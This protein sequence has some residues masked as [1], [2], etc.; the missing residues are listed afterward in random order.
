MLQA[1]A[2]A[3]PVASIRIEKSFTGAG[4]SAVDVQHLLPGDVPSYTITV[5]NTGST[6]VTNLQVA[7]Q[8]SASCVR[9]LGSLAPGTSTQF[10]CTGPPVQQGGFTTTATVTGQSGSTTLTSSDSTRVNVATI[11]LAKSV[12]A[13]GSTG[14]AGDVLSYTFAI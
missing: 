8:L 13:P 14:R 3:V 9:S 1:T 4:S 7:D 5:T 2:F 12:A 10:T 6:T 11:S